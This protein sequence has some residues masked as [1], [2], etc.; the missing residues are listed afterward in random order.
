MNRTFCIVAFIVAGLLWAGAALADKIVLKN[1]EELSGRVV[2][3][4]GGYTVIRLTSGEHKRVRSN[5]IAKVIEVEEEETVEEKETQEAAAPAPESPRELSGNE[6]QLQ[7]ALER[8]IPGIT[9]AEMPLEDILV[10]L[11]KLPECRDVK[12]VVDRENVRNGRM[13]VTLQGRNVSVRKA[14]ESM[15]NPKGLDFAIR[16]GAVLISTRTRIAALE[17][18]G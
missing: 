17:K 12:F 1:G 5:E 4:G 15:L 10:F 2:G 16:D 6:G 13:V 18:E 14:L 8:Q 7:A 11:K 9:F 3:S